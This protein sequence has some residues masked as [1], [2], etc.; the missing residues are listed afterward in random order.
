LKKKTT[1]DLPCVKSNGLRLFSGEEKLMVFKDSLKDELTR[2]CRASPALTRQSAIAI[3][4]G[5]MT[6]L[7]P[8]PSTALL[9]LCSA[10]EHL[11]AMTLNDFERL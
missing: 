1:Q 6:R 4:C 3:Q 11:N 9:L 10:K 5:Q 8:S 2:L 7:K